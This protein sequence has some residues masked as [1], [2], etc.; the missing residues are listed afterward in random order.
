MFA[1]TFCTVSYPRCG[2]VFQQK[3]QA[4]KDTSLTCW[5]S[6]NMTSAWVPK[7][8]GHAG[9]PSKSRA[10]QRVL[11]LLMCLWSSALFYFAYW[12]SEANSRVFSWVSKSTLSFLLVSYS[13]RELA[14]IQLDFQ[15]TY[16]RAWHW[17][18]EFLHTIWGSK[19]WPIFH[20]FWHRK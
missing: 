4:P 12:R 7:T 11:V 15:N 5:P 10:C 2:L 6:W 8:T 20:V 14:T 9:W 17:V 13:S 18:L 16:L 1:N 19:M 3:W